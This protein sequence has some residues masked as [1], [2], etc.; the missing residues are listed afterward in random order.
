MNATGDGK[1]RATAC[2]KVN[3][4]EVRFRLDTAADV[5]TLQKRFV[6]KSPVI[7]S[8]QS[9]V[10]WNGT[11]MEPLGETKLDVVNEKTGQTLP[12]TFTVV[13]NN[14]NCLL[15]LTTSQELGMVTI[16]HDKCI[17]KV[18]EEPGLLGT[19]TLQTDPEV[20][21]QVLPC[22]KI[23]FAL[24][25]KVREEI[26][27]LIKRG[28]LIRQTEPTDWV[29]Q[30][31]IVEKENG[32]L[33]ICIDPRP[34]NKAL[35]R[36]HYKL[37]TLDDVL[38]EFKD[39]KTFTKLDVKEAFWHIKLDEES[40]KLTKMITPFGRVRWISM[41]FVLNVSSEILQRHLATAL[42]DLPGLVN[43]ADDILVIG[44]G[45]TKEQAMKDHDTKY[46]LLKRRCSEKG[47]KLNKEK[48]R[49][50]QEEVTFMGHK[51]SDRGIE[52]GARKV[53][54]IRKMPTPKD[55]HDVRRFC[56]MVQYLSKFLDKLSDRLQPLRE[57]TN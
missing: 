32:S 40:S 48:A 37:T 17:A 23:P 2:L 27:S 16:N 19:A 35:K 33:R 41:P 55:V 4:C 22:R 56:G 38:P 3:N 26:E 24:E 45:P 39:A 5:N 20:R 36:E 54:A 43:V 47:I 50:K 29:S 18:E 13:K 1:R 51:I 25:K 6:K 12:V 52:P 31:A 8:N 14:L 21:P 11:Q 49:V 57:L 9:L 15:S 28:I 42:D 7:K 46:E 53:E 34:L 10:I 44:N 30:M